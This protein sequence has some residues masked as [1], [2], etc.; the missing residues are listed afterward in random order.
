MTSVRYSVKVN[1]KLHGFFQGERSSLGGPF[2]TL[3][4]CSCY[5]VLY[6]IVKYHSHVDDF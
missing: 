1:R 3:L 2:A 4:V 5:V 6:G